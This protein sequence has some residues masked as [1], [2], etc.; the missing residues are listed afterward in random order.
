MALSLVEVVR[1]IK[2][3]GAP[4]KNLESAARGTL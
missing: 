2:A 3:P 1:Q 4:T